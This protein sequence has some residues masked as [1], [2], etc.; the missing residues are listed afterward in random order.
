LQAA[1]LAFDGHAGVIADAGA[2]AGQGVEK[3][4]F[5]GIGITAQHHERRRSRTAGWRLI[6]LAVAECW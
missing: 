3:S 5:A 2:Q 1:L 6:S 4:G